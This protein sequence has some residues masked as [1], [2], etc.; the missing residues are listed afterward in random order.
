MTPGRSNA[1]L[2]RASSPAVLASAI[3]SAANCKTN[4]AAFSPPVSTTATDISRRTGVTANSNQHSTASSTRT[5]RTAAELIDRLAELV[6]IVDGVD[7]IDPN[8]L[9]PSL[10]RVGFDVND[11]L[12]HDQDLLQKDDIPLEWYRRL[13]DDGSD[14]Y[15]SADGHTLDRPSSSPRFSTRQLLRLLTMDYRGLIHPAIFVI[16]VWR[17]MLE[18]VYDMGFTEA[19]SVAEELY[20]S[21][22]EPELRSITMY[23]VYFY[24]V[25]SKK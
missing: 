8:D 20:K 4:S 11:V 13:D 9:E 24:Y 2:H 7:Y 14:R 5:A 12:A 25:K 1:N 3:A 22:N 17:I 23:L 6:D 21:A 15:D 18:Y 16:D 10:G 19:R